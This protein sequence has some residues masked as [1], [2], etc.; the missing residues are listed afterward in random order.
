MIVRESIEMSKAS[1]YAKNK[2]KKGSFGELV[3]E[4][5]DTVFSSLGESC[6]QA[7]YFHLKNRYNISRENIPERIEDFFD[8]LEGI[9]GL[10]AKLIEIE[11]MKLLF[12][13][14]QTFKCSLK[15]E[16]LLFKDYLKMLGDF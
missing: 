11:I 1:D 4:T 7:V 16:G 12:S 6:K 10:G 2:R 3:M 15:Q 9:F 13:K 5:V 14:V 8:A